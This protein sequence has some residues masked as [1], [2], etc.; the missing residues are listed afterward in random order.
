[1]LVVRNNPI[2]IDWY[3][4]RLQTYIHGQLLTR[5][6]IDTAQYN[7]YGRCY[8]NKEV[9][10]SGYIAENYTSSGNYKEVYW[11]SSLSAISFFG[12]SGNILRKNASAMADVHLV[13]FTD[14]AKLKPSVAH[15]ADEEVRQD[16]TNLLQA[17]QWGFMHQSTEFGIE[18][19]LKE[20]PG[21]RR[22]DRLKYVDMHPVHCFRLNL[23]LIYDPNKIC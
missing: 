8:R 6:A 9:G 18:N 10:G 3:V 12:L 13:F 4:Q 7:A 23:K 15:R 17:S 14:L 22:D 20:Y 5:W 19:V 21:S 1:M 11:D 16:V 2:G